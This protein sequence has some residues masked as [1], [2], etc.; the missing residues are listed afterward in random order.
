MGLFA[1]QAWKRR[2]S[3]RFG[4]NLSFKIAYLPCLFGCACWLVGMM[5]LVGGCSKSSIAEPKYGPQVIRNEEWIEVDEEPPVITPT[6]MSPSPSKEYVWI[7]GQW[8]FRPG[9]RRWVWE[10]GK[11][12]VPPPGD[13]Y[14]AKP[15]YLRFRKVLGRTV[16]WNPVASRFERVDSGEDRWLWTPGQWFERKGER[17]S[18]VEKEPVCINS[19]GLGE[20]PTKRLD[21]RS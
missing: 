3:L 2:I 9:S 14:Y 16:R 21:S 10:Y 6:E 12:C 1:S 17:V 20:P 4:G 13:T 8:A 5:C 15:V 19:Q 18:P 7:D 11:W